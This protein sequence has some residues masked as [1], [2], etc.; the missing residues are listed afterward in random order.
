MR[1]SDLMRIWGNVGE[2]IKCSKNNLQSI[3]RIH[4]M[5]FP[6]LQKFCFFLL[7]WESKWSALQKSKVV[8]ASLF[9]IV[10]YSQSLRYRRLVKW[11]QI[12]SF[13]WDFLLPD[14]LKGKLAYFL[15]SHLKFFCTVLNLHLHMPWFT[16]WFTYGSFFPR[17]CKLHEHSDFLKFIIVSTIPNSI[18]SM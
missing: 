11:S 4:D 18:V 14:Q 7:A 3:S 5:L 13:S 8:I 9:M 12:L 6:K 10:N 2:D 17:D 1:G 15:S 16:H